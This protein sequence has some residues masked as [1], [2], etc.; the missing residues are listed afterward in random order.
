MTKIIT[1][2]FINRPICFLRIKKVQKKAM[3]YSVISIIMIGL[4]FVFLF[5]YQNYISSKEYD[6]QIA[7]GILVIDDVVKDI[8]KDMLKQSYNHVNIVGQNKIIRNISFF[9]YTSYENFINNYYFKKANI[10]MILVSNDSIVT[11]DFAINK[12][13]ISILN[14]SYI[15]TDIY[16]P[17]NNF[18][19][20][21]QSYASG[22]YNLSIYFYNQSDMLLFFI[23]K[24][25]NVSKD[26]HVYLSN[27]ANVTITKNSI[28]FK[29]MLYYTIDV[30]TN[31]TNNVWFGST[32]NVT[33]GKNGYFGNVLMN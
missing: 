14:G 32:L 31:K 6:L 9:N 10:N 3:I 1:N 20:I 29:N 17:Q 5:M 26:S 13:T 11:K 18:S 33:I 22:N 16:I 30:Y 8:Q 24:L 27:G 21:D 28:Y 23:N 4:L 7:L 12:E 25:V 15:R 19:I 2:N